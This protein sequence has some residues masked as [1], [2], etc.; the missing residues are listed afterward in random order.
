MTCKV[1]F[2]PRLMRVADSGPVDTQSHD[3]AWHSVTGRRIR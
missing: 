2:G 1:T 3:E